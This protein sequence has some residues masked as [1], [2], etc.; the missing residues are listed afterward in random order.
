[1]LLH[2]L[3]LAAVAR[4]P[5][6]MAVIAPNGTLSY[7]E[8]DQQ[9]AKLATLLRELGVRPGDRVGIHLAKSTHS[10]IATQG[11]LRCGARHR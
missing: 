8:L 2:E 9:A 7:S 1:M 5:Q 6:A 3:V 4:S 10:V 11:A